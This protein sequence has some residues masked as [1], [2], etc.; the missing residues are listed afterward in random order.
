MSGPVLDM[1]VS[2]LHNPGL[3]RPVPIQASRGQAL[4]CNLGAALNYGCALL[5]NAWVTCDFEIMPQLKMM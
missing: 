2:W 5:L 4:L 1:S 3:P